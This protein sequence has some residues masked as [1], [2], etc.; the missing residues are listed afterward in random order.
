MSIEPVPKP[1]YTIP[2]LKRWTL[3]TA[4]TQIGKDLA[5][6]LKKPGMNEAELVVDETG[7]GLA[8]VEIIKRELADAGLPNKVIG[9]TITGGVAVNRQSLYRWHVAKRQPG[10]PWTIPFIRNDEMQC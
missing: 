4:Y 6:F 5:A 9:I 3:G 7:V 8:V 1:V 2:T 10:V